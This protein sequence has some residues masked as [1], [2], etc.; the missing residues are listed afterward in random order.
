MEND[1]L[2]RDLLQSKRNIQDSQRIFRRVV[3]DC[4]RELENANLTQGERLD[5]ED[6][7]FDA[8]EKLKSCDETIADVDQSLVDLSRAREQGDRA[9]NTEMALVVIGV[10][11][12]LVLL[13]YFLLR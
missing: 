6:Q 2:V 7:V 10:A 4:R 12:L 11:F 5:L 3:W 1:E 13:L 9:D 8:M